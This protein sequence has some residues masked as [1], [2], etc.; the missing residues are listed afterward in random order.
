MATLF[1]EAKSIVTEHVGYFIK[2][3]GLDDSLVCRDFRHTTKRGA[4]SEKSRQ[5]SKHPNLTT[6]GYPSANRYRAHTSLSLMGMI[7]GFR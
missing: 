3:D 6:L 7:T 2:E 4:I 1:G 5:F